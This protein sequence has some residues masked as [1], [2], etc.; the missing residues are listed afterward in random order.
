ML[1]ERASYTRGRQGTVG[2]LEKATKTFG[3]PYNAVAGSASAT[4]NTAT[5]PTQR[6]HYY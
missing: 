3:T 5:P 6:S 4:T 1:V 2:I